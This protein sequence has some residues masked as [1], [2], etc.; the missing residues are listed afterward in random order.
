M[1]NPL[2][3]EEHNAFE[4]EWERVMREDGGWPALWRE[5]SA[6]LE[7]GSLPKSME[8]GHQCQ[9]DEPRHREAEQVFGPLSRFPWTCLPDGG[10]LTDPFARAIRWGWH[11]RYS[12]E[13]ALRD[14]VHRD[15]A[16]YLE[17]LT[18]LA[19]GAYE[20]GLV[21]LLTDAS[22]GHELRVVRLE[23]E[24][25]RSVR[26]AFLAGSRY[27]RELQGKPREKG[28]HPRI[29]PPPGGSV[30][31]WDVRI[32]VLVG[33]FNDTRGPKLT[34]EANDGSKKEAYLR[35]A[36][37]AVALAD[38]ISRRVD[39]PKPDLSDG[40]RRAEWEDSGWGPSKA[41]GEIAIA[42]LVRKPGV[43]GYRKTA[44]DAW[45]AAGQIQNMIRARDMEGASK[46]LRGGVPDCDPNPC[47]DNTTRQ[48]HY[49]TISGV[50]DR[51]KGL[52]A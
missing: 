46:M 11:C 49:S 4:R 3:K 26:E 38:Y 33:F 7:A 22:D 31:D 16:G 15:A 8:R 17:D 32:A 40:H 37:D 12:A 5:E 44:D 9:D 47:D 25:A 14:T 24:I 39:P 2:T 1:A 27:E 34:A 30:L 43:K 29:P 45:R 36:C 19:T 13:V 20:Q 50:W 23:E 35:S 41:R 51:F 48:T 42:L 6:A 28:E 21:P 18:A 52:T 10:L